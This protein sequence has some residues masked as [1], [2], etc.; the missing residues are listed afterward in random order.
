M[1]PFGRG[2]GGEVGSR[3]NGDVRPPT[4]RVYKI[5]TMDDISVKEQVSIRVFLFYVC[6]IIFFISPPTQKVP[7]C[8]PLSVKSLSTV[9]L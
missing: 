2:G 8:S 7:S 4:E 5:L 3:K 9:K 6:Y 1:G